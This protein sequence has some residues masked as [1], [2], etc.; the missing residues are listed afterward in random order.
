MP[1][2]PDHL[3]IRVHDL[4]TT[5]A[6]FAE[7]GFTVQRGG[8]HADGTTHSALIGFA[9]GSYIE[10]IAFLKD[11]R[12][13]RWWDEHQRAGEG[14]V[15]FALLPESVARTVEA[16]YARGLYYDGPIPGGRI[17]PD[18][19][20]LEWQIG[21][22]TTRDLPFLCGDLTPR[23]LRVAEG[24]ARTH[25]NGATGLAAVNV[26][27]SNLE[28]SIA[29]YRILLGDVPV[30]RGA[31]TGLGVYFATLPIGRTTVTLLSPVARTRADDDPDAGNTTALAEALRSHLAI[32]GEGVFSAA[33]HVAD[34]AQ[35]RALPLSLS[36]GARLEF[37]YATGG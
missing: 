19:T 20:R 30:H 26:A 11:A 28:K 4:K 31:L 21:R 10:L 6:D 29:R 2:L 1:L 24:E 16:T 9:D 37:V 18:G 15:D 34:A 32:R 27:V 17:R 33:I 35:A 5:I 7:L 8:T 22:P 13:H 36:H 25:R 23:F 3:V 14:F 12:E